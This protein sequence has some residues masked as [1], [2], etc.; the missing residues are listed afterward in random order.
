M[1]S[2]FRNISHSRPHGKPWYK[3]PWHITYTGSVKFDTERGVESL[4]L[5]RPRL[6]GSNCA[7]SEVTAMMPS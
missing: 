4:E 7:V 3:K 1:G 5:T 6:A 2:G